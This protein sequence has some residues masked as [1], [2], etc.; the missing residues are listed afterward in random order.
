MKTIYL[1]SNF[2]FEDVES[3]RAAISNEEEIAVYSRGANPTIEE[4]NTALAQLE[5]KESALSFASG[6]AAISAVLFTFLKANDHIIVHNH[7]YS[8]ARKLIT[9]RLP[10]LGIEVTIL[11]EKDLIQIEK[12]I[13]PNTRMIY[14]EHPSFF[15]FEELPLRNILNLSKEKGIL[16]AVDN[17]YLG[18][19]NLKSDI[20]SQIDFIIHS[21]TKI[22]S[23]HSDVMG[24]SVCTSTKYRSLIFEH[25]LMT[26]GGVMTPMNA[27]LSL[28]GL[29]TYPARTAW[30]KK[31]VMELVQFC[32]NHPE[33]KKVNFPWE[34][35]THPDY[36]F[37][38]GLFSIVLR[39]DDEK[40]IM[41][42]C[43]R[44]KVFKLA[45]SY[46]GFDA[47]LMPNIVF[48]RLGMDIISEPG[49]MRISVGLQ[50]ASKLIDDLN[51]ALKQY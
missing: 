7:I 43:K 46:G 29:K 44:I 34:G 2:I 8:W 25:G 39:T 10:L 33:I 28:R 4:F 22:V 9:T 38:V 1:N 45:V 47:Y 36:H 3:F 48:K 17:T 42:F 14:L 51:Q 12:Y 31:E 21:T 18:P 41:E 30:I 32:R 13:K 11:E 23:G 6:M 49:L 40:R 50:T 37:P 27:M 35:D 15:F 26:L 5:G 16:T 19:N 24:G 20:C